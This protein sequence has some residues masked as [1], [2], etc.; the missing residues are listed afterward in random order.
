MKHLEFKPFKHGVQT[1]LIR[2]CQNI[3][4][5]K[6][7]KKRITSNIMTFF[8]TENVLNVLNQSKN[9]EPKQLFRI[10]YFIIKTGQVKSQY[11]ICSS[12]N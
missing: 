10:F 6:A 11:C 4:Q 12:F 2:I 9:L 3:V 7:H 5:L 1:L 8:K